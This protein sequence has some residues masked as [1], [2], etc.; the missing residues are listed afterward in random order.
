MKDG[1]CLRAREQIDHRYAM[2]WKI[3][4]CNVIFVCCGLSCTS[5][6]SSPLLDVSSSG[7]HIPYNEKHI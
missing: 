1:Y 7:T 5:K 3:E 2:L 4:I 6:L